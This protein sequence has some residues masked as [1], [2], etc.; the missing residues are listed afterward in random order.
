ACSSSATGRTV[1]SMSTRFGTAMRGSRTKCR[2]S[3]RS[4]RSVPRAVVD[5]AVEVVIV[6]GGRVGQVTV[7]RADLGDLA[8]VAKHDLQPVLGFPVAFAFQGDVDVPV[9]VRVAADRRFV[10]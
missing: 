5:D 8:T 2:R 6:I 10:T 7:A 9:A 1:M 3:R 4:G